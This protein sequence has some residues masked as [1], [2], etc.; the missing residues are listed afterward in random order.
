MV[1]MQ[2]VRL[3]NGES[4]YNR[5]WQEKGKIVE[6]LKQMK[7]PTETRRRREDADTSDLLCRANRGGNDNKLAEASRSGE[8]GL[9]LRRNKSFLK[10]VLQP[11]K[12]VSQQQTS[13]QR[14]VE[15]RKSKNVIRL[16]PLPTTTTAAA[17]TITAAAAAAAI[18]DAILPLLVSYL[19]R[20]LLLLNH[21]HSVAVPSATT[22]A[23]AYAYAYAYTYTFSMQHCNFTN[24]AAVRLHRRQ[25]VGFNNRNIQIL[26][27]HVNDARKL[28]RLWTSKLQAVQIY[29]IRHNNKEHQRQSTNM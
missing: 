28:L 12:I 8:C 15:E 14:R 9:Q 23:A 21:A 11:L 22:I 1:L 10:R 3:S 4:I 6:L 5:S 2:F 13:K 20:L 24:A 26:A 27:I 29:S 17:T 19:E 25:F 18:A 16:L 7:R